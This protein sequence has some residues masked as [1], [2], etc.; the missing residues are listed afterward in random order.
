MQ[1]K[2]GIFFENICF[3]PIMHG[4][5][6]FAAAVIRSFCRWQP[7]AIAVEFP[8]TLKKPLIRGLERL[9][10]LSVLV[11]ELKDNTHV[12]L[13]LE[14]TDGLVEA[15]RAALEH[16]LPL[17]LID[18]DM[19]H[20][21]QV[22]EPLPDSYA[23]SRI[24]LTAYC[25]AYA[26]RAKQ[27]VSEDLLR[28]ANMAYHLDRLRRQY[29]R[30]LFVCGISHYPRILSRLGNRQVQ[31]I[32]RQQRAGVLLAH[33]HQQSSREIMTEIPYLAAAYE[34]QRQHLYALWRRDPDAVNPLDRLQLQEKLLQEA[35]ARHWRHSRER[36]RPHQLR[37]LRQ[38]A[39]NY[40]LLQG[41]LAPDF[42]QLTI[43]ARGAVD[44]NF[45]YEVWDLGS[46]YPWQDD[47]PQLPVIELKGEDLFLNQKKIRF[48]RSF[49]VKR[50]RLV[51]VGIRNKRL[52]EARPGEWRRKWQ[53]LMICSYPPE[54]LVVEGWGHY[55]K[56]KTAHIL[57]AENTR[58]QPFT[59][60]L[61]DGLDLRETIRNWHEGKLYVKEERLLSGKVGSVVLIFDED[62]PSPGG[63]EN[64]PWRVTW[65]GEHEQ[66]SDMAFYATPAGEHLVGPGVSRCRYGGFMLTYPP[67][68]VYD[69][70]RDSFFD[71]ATSKPERLLLAAIDYCEEKQIAYIAAK[72]PRSWWH[73]V[74]ARY[75]KKIV[76]L[77]LGMFSPVFLKKIRTFHVL[78]GHHVRDYAYKYIS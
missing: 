25:Q 6:E 42:Y 19:D 68:R 37:V 65:L 35:C 7:E 24:G 56:K 45:A 51:P 18:L 41:F 3:V 28:E 78:D 32:G 62:R 46:H 38:F 71:V 72:P 36:V 43:A 69:I 23:L 63:R 20:F 22:R 53:G 75:G 31:P 8:H 57:A 54:D 9:P 26:A 47:N 30:V 55:V 50:R 58:T 39:R 52:R 70:W 27:A 60:S 76:Y 33:M 77:P 61:L 67:M 17:H 12:Y 34:R 73:S 14:P 40:A 59:T 64:F 44:D 11:F 74:A 4:R 15:A 49:R 13:P 5:L 2:S 1:D 21:V 29:K 10:L 48:H 16:Q 66:E